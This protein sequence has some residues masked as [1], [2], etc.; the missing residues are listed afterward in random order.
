[1]AEDKKAEE[2][3]DLPEKK[4]RLGNQDLEGVVGGIGITPIKPIGVD[5]SPSPTPTTSTQ[6]M[7][8]GEVVYDT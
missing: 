3:K 2:I 8:K 7:V 6:T 5:P 4:T 1:M